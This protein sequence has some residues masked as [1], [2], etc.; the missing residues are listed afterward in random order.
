MVGRQVK[1]LEAKYRVTIAFIKTMFKMISVVK[2]NSIYRFGKRAY[3]G[4]IYIS[5]EDDDDD[6]NR[7]FAARQ[8]LER[9]R[10]KNVF[11]Y[12]FMTSSIQS[13]VCSPTQKG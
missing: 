4:S 5:L 12:S 3:L 9:A 11:H 10:V 6:E 8:H 7:I 2:K 13:L 1:S